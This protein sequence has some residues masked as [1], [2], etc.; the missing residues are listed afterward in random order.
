V[1][2]PS[3]ATSRSS[4]STNSDENMPIAMSPVHASTRDFTSRIVLRRAMN[5][6]GISVAD[7]ASHAHNAATASTPAGRTSGTRRAAT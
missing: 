3:S 5:D 7:A 2:P 1:K 6:K 4:V